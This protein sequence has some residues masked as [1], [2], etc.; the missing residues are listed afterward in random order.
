MV[1]AAKQMLHRSVILMINKRSFETA[2]H[3]TVVPACGST[4]SRP[5]AFQELSIVPVH[6]PS[7]AA[8][9]VTPYISFRRC[10]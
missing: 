10:V 4:R 6:A 5:E 7:L 8:A 3:V 1:D 2:L 9:L